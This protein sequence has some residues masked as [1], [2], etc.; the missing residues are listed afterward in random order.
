MEVVRDDEGNIMYSEFPYWNLIIDYLP[1]KDLEKLILLSKN[2]M[3]LATDIKLYVKFD[4]QISHKYDKQ[5][6]QRSSPGR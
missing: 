5:W 1:L 3:T 4:R 6:S 2:F